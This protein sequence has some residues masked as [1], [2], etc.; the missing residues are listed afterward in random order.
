MRVKQ[1]E[2]ISQ[3]EYAKSSFGHRPVLFC[4]FISLRQA[5]YHIQV[6]QLAL[7]HRAIPIPETCRLD[8]GLSALGTWFEDGSSAVLLPIPILLLLLGIDAV[9]GAGARY[10]Q[11]EATYHGGEVG[12]ARGHAGRLFRGTARDFVLG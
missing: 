1:Q 5:K 10:G 11:R 4:V 8:A 2:A 12:L 7:L 6:I 9:T 3:K